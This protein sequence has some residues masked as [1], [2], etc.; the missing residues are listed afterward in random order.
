[1]SDNAQQCIG[2]FFGFTSLGPAG[3]HLSLMHR[4][5]RTEDNRARREGGERERKDGLMHVFHSD[6]LHRLLQP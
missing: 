1:M 6:R 3:G 2:G 5:V 4:H